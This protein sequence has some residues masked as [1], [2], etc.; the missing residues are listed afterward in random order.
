MKIFMPNRY[1][2]T[3]LAAILFAPAL[4]QA[5]VASGQNGFSHGFCHPLNGLDHLLAMLAVGLWAAQIGGRSVWFVPGTFVSVMVFGGYLGMKGI[6]L[7]WVEP[8]I[9]ASVL[10]LG[11]C[12]ATTVRLPQFY[13]VL[14]VG[15]FALYH[16]HTHGSEMPSTVSSLEFAVGFSLATTLLHGAG[17]VFGLGI[18]R[19]LSTPAIRFAG[20]MITCAGIYLA[21]A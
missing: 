11:L 6:E 1:W 10:V 2:I 4:A 15:F 16:G 7:P 19:M 9:L 17:I 21:L 13:S 5:H 8:G 20:G 14:L 18:Q 3:V 12:I